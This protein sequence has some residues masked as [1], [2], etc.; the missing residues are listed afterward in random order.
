MTSSH[1]IGPSSDLLGNEQPLERLAD[2]SKTLWLDRLTGTEHRV[3][4]LTGILLTLFGI[5]SLIFLTLDQIIS[6][7]NVSGWQITLLILVGMVV[8]MLP[9]L[10]T[11][12]LSNRKLVVKYKDTTITIQELTEKLE[13]DQKNLQE[14]I[15]DIIALQSLVFSVSDII[16]SEIDRD[17]D[18]NLEK[19]RSLLFKKFYRIT[20]DMKDKEAA[21]ALRE[22]LTKSFLSSLDANVPGIKE[23]LADVKCYHGAFD[24]EIDDAF[25]KAVVRFQRKARIDPADGIFGP[26]TFEK[27]TEAVGREEL[28]REPPCER[29]TTELAAR[30]ADMA[31][32]PPPRPDHPGAIAT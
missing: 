31:A 23:A 24:A 16:L 30:Q 7:E 25:M 14:T 2:R 19:R 26:S 28:R 1:E 12:L 13:T 20:E 21:V 15:L 22:R 18:K 8:I 5:A 4:R 17:F 32:Q 10:T 29:A 9:E 27:L 3:L 11:L 6:K